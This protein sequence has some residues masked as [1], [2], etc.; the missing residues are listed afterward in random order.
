MNQRGRV[1]SIVFVD[2]AVLLLLR[3]RLTELEA[4]RRWLDRAGSDE[5]A[6][7]FAGTLLWLLAAVF[8]LGLLATAIA[9]LP[10]AI[11]RAGDRLSRVLLPQAVRRLAAGS[12]G[13]GVLLAPVAAIAE[14]GSA[15]P[16][17]SSVP[18]PGWPVDPPPAPP[19]TPA[20]PVPPVP[21]AQPAPPA[22]PAPPVPPAKPVESTPPDAP[23]D[24]VT[25]R[26]GDS[27]W[28]IAA[29]RLGATAS[30]ARVAATWP[31]WYAANRGAIGDDPDRLVPGQVLHAP[32]R[33]HR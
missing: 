6:A 20:P 13:L 7:G 1:L 28:L 31:A 26:P 29:R 27:L 21:P 25:V 2:G 32:A 19:A 5:V 11:G 14:T 17:A 16:P 22:P 8:G 10:G 15:P 30:P 23:T 12:A 3:P 33:E 4:P 9:R 24:S 18:A